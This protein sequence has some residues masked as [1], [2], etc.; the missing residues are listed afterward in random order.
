MEILELIWEGKI[1]LAIW[2]AFF[3]FIFVLVLF[4]FWRDIA[5]SFP[6]FLNDQFVVYQYI[7]IA[8]ESTMQ[9][10]GS[11]HSGFKLSF[12]HTYYI[13]IK[14]WYNHFK[15]LYMLTCSIQ[16]LA[17]FL[18]RHGWFEN[19]YNRKLSRQAAKTLF[20]LSI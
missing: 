12:L 5:S 20:N 6:Q 11:M 2:K 8:A 16:E 1:L 14:P 7:L 4:C 13:L 10:S 18:C 9:C 17:C 15:L 19:N 3:V